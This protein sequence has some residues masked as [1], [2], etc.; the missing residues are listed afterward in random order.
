MATRSP[1]PDGQVA[2]GAD[3]QAVVGEVE[4]GLGDLLAGVVEKHHGL[5]P[6]DVPQRAPLRQ[7]WYRQIVTCW[8][9][10]VYRC[11]FL[12]SCLTLPSGWGHALFALTFLWVLVIVAQ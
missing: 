4:A 6:R 1:S 5:F 3:D 12:F 2:G 8:R 9:S 10:H 7:K 11:A